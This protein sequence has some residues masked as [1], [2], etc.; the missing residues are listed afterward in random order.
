MEKFSIAVHTTGNIGNT[1]LRD[2]SGF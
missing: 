2:G 1:M